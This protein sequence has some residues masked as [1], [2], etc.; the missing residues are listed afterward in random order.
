MWTD[1]SHISTLSLTD[2]LTPFIILFCTFL[3][4]RFNFSSSTVVAPAPQLA[5]RCQINAKHRALLS[6]WASALHRLFASVFIQHFSLAGWQHHP[7]PPQDTHI[8]TQHQH[9][10]SPQQLSCRAPSAPFRRGWLMHRPY[11]SYGDDSST[12]RHDTWCSEEVCVC[13]SFCFISHITYP[14]PRQSFKV[15]TVSSY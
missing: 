15:C 11:K 10:T 13:F 3:L 2:D 4:S 8:Y 9:H 6:L 1:V 5:L 7:S 14:P 12:P